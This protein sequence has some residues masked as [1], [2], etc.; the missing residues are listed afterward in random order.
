[1]PTGFT[2][3]CAIITITNFLSAIRRSTIKLRDISMYRF[4]QIRF[5][6]I[7]FYVGLIRSIDGINI[8]RIL[9]STLTSEKDI[10]RECCLCE[11][12]STVSGEAK[13]SDATWRSILPLVRLYRISLRFIMVTSYLQLHRILLLL[14]DDCTPLGRLF[15]RYHERLRAFLDFALLRT[16]NLL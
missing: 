6:K 8:T 7:L 4:K 1:M 3:S 5:R 13:E 11:R 2:L 12:S 16:C 15:D 9:W 14:D 10:Y